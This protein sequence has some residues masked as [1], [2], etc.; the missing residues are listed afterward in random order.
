MAYK[1]NVIV[2]SLL[3]I[4]FWKY[5]IYRKRFHYF[6]NLINKTVRNQKKD[7]LSIP[8]IIINYNRLSDLKKMV[9]F[10][11]ERNHKNIVII[12][13]K[14][15][16]PPLL[17]YYE[18]IKDVVNVKKMDENYGHLVFW[19]NKEIYDEF[20]QG[21][22][23]VT[24]SDIIP[25]QNLPDNYLEILMHIL[26]TNKKVSKVGFALKIDNIPNTFSQKDK[27][28]EWEKKFWQTEINTDIYLADI[29]TTFAIYPPKYRYYYPSFYKAIRV[30][31]DFTATHG[32]WYI[33]TNELTDEDRYYFETSNNSNSWKV[34]KDG[35]FIGDS[36]YEK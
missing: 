26:D 23:V 8:I 11:L 35:D 31:G 34:D 15:T 1:L 28:L 9:S 6:I 17:N 36:L 2:K 29:D 24:D 10:F 22:Y 14:S 12:D 16:Y 32:G 4:D 13:N 20:S 3:T 18:Q 5:Y 27:V 21:Y 7:V 19:L 30:A 33:N 25:N